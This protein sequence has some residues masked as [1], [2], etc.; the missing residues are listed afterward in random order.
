MTNDILTVRYDMNG[1]GSLW[2]G[3]AQIVEE[4]PVDGDEMIYSAKFAGYAPNGCPILEVKFGNLDIAKGFTAVYMGV[5]DADD[6]EVLE[7]LGLIE[8]ALV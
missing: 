7:Y 1:D 5:P 4:L 2:E 8:Y 3:F 6:K